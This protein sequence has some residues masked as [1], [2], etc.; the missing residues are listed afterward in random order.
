M[1]DKVSNKEIIRI[2]SKYDSFLNMIL[3]HPVLRKDGVTAYLQTDDGVETQVF[4]GL[5][6]FIQ[7]PAGHVTDPDV[8]DFTNTN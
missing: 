8:A 6:E 7:L 1:F 5:H 4:G 2:F 3:K